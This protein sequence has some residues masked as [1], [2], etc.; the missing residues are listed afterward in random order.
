[1]QVKTC[2]R[3]FGQPGSIARLIEKLVQTSAS[4]I[5]VNY[6][7]L[8][9]IIKTPGNINRGHARVKTSKLKEMNGNIL[10][11]LRTYRT[12]YIHSVFYFNFQALAHNLITL[13]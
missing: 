5:Y 8:L 9:T 6:C 4:L 7:S 11:Q 13:V 2:E 10:T 12:N 3:I 1:M